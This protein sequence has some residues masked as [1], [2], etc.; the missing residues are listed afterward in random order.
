MSMLIDRALKTNGYV[1]DCDMVMAAS[2]KYRQSQDLFSQFF[3]EKIVVD[4]GKTLTK[5]ELHTEYGI[6]YSNNAGGKAPTSRE[7]AENMDKLFKKN[8]KGKWNGIG[9]VYGDNT[10]E[11]TELEEPV[12]T[13]INDLG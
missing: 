3:D 1:K 11:N 7:T 4:A 2:N 5:T 10:D 8:I 6:W 12:E 13:G 9:L